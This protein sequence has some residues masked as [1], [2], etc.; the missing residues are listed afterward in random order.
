MLLLNPNKLRFATASAFLTAFLL[1]NI[2]N[3]QD[4]TPQ[5]LTDMSSNSSARLR[6]IR[7]PSTRR[8]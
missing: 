1:V 8:M 4:K 2:S 6:S 5:D 3:A 7:L